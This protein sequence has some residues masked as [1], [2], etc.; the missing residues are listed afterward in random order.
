A[1]KYPIRLRYK[2]TVP[3]DGTGYVRSEILHRNR[4]ITCQS[5]AIRNRTGARGTFEAFIKQQAALTFL[6]DQGTP[7]ANTWYWYPYTQFI[8]EG[9]QI[10]VQQLTCKEDD[11][12]ELHIIGYAMYGPEALVE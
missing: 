9:E 3:E 1:K 7:G 11:V 5:I 10:E 4:V 8:K 2:A 6:F 12:L